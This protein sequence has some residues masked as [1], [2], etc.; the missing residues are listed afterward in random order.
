[1]KI[2]RL[3][4]INI[5][6]TDLAASERFYCEILGLSKAFEFHKDGALYGFYVNVGDTTFVE[7]FTQDEG[8]NPPNALLRH[9][10]LEVDD[11]DAVI[12][13]VRAKGWE[14]SDKKRGCDQS[15]QAWITD[16]SGVPIELMQYTPESS[17]F[18]G[19]PCEV[20]W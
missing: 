18:T 12:A 1:M 3:A 10:C 9:L 16:P 7:I 4:H 15:W 14:I 8:A 20:N 11:L 5:G 13:D 6:S 2:T 19:A 17:Q